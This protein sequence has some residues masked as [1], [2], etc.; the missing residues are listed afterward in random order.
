MAIVGQNTNPME[1][2]RIQRNY[3]TAYEVQQVLDQVQPARSRVQDF[4]DRTRQILRRQGTD[5]LK[6]LGAMKNISSFY[7]KLRPTIQKIGKYAAPMMGAGLGAAIS[8]I[9]PKGEYPITQ[10]F[11]NY[12]PAL[13]S[14]ITKGA[15]HLGVDLGVP[16]GT[17]LRL[18]ISGNVEVG[19]DP[20]GFGAYVKVK[21]DDGAEYRFSHLSQ[22]NPAIARAAETGKKI[23]AGTAFGISGGARGTAGAGNTTGAHLDITARDQRGNYIDPM[24]IDT[25]RRALGL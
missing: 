9:L 11:G 12:N 8:K 25:I 23:A 7:E 19:I 5:T 2:E 13:Y 16:Q 4:A 20:R 24:K 21:G 14:G 17:E 18:P 22:I 10:G 6:D 3:P 1:M 15:K